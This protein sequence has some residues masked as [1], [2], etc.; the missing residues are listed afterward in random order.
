MEIVQGTFLAAAK[1]TP[2]SFKKQ[3]KPLE[4]GVST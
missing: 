4:V 2:G 3:L 1:Q